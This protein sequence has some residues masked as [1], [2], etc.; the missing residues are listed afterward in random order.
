MNSQYNFHDSDNS[1]LPALD[2]QAVTEVFCMRCGSLQPAGIKCIN[3]EC[4][5]KGQ[6]YAKYSC[7]ICNLHDDDATKSIY[8]C[9]Y[10]NVWLKGKGL[11][12]DYRHCMRCNACIALSEYDLHTCIP[13][14]L[15]GICPPICHETLFE[16]TEPLRGMHCGHENM[17]LSCFHSYASKVCARAIM[18]TL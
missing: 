9:P 5:S 7:L 11:G 6:P 14:R 8:H 18:S 2:R 3:P 13:Q 16:S 10:C 1:S 4:D 12:I 15:Q 17:H